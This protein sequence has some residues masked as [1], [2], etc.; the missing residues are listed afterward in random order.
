MQNET[1]EEKP[2]CLE[3]V[4]AIACLA[5]Y[6]RQANDTVCLNVMIIC[7]CSVVDYDRFVISWLCFTTHLTHCVYKKHGRG[8]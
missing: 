7:V 8:I 4:R 5:D 2:S 6:C 3:G 1:S